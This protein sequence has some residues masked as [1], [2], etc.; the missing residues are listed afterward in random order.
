MRGFAWAFVQRA[1][2][3]LSWGSK[4]TAWWG[5]RIRAAKGIESAG[6]H[7]PLL[8]RKE[9]WGGTAANRRPEPSASAGLLGIACS[10]GAPAW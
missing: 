6:V 2:E 9:H 7:A 8:P 4:S 1:G 10:K 5:E 3:R